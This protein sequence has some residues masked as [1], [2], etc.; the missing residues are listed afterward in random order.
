MRAWSAFPLLIALIAGAAAAQLVLAVP[1][2]SGWSR[3]DRGCYVWNPLGQEDEAVTWTGACVNERASGEGKLVW[4]HQ[5]RPT[6]VYVGAMELGRLNG[7]G[8]FTFPNGDVYEGVY[9][10][11]VLNGPGELRWGNGNRYRGTFRNFRPDGHGVLSFTNGDRFDGEFKAGLMD[12]LGRAVWANGE[13]YEGHF[14]RGAPDGQG[15][16]T[17]ASQTYSGTWRRGC[18]RE[19]NRRRALMVAEASCKWDAPAPQ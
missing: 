15:T 12:G 5:G 17:A 2:Q 6:S 11:D 18:F 9:R 19:G 1:G 4:L 10:D 3:T 16:L 14:A 7:P 8:V 13:H